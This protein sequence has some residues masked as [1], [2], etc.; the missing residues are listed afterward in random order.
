M[1]SMAQRKKRREGH[2]ALGA[3]EFMPGGKGALTV[4][5]CGR[6]KGMEIYEGV[7]FV[8]VKSSRYNLL[9]MKDYLP[10]LGR[11]SGD[12]AFRSQEDTYERE[13]VQGFF[14][15]KDNVFSLMLEDVMWESRDAGEE[16]A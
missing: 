8:R 5:I 16:E 9:I 14:M 15:H 7:S 3:E 10:V 12:I 1:K 11:I 2:R 13:N 6:E 4:R